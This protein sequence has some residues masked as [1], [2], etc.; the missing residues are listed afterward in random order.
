M[1]TLGRKMCSPIVPPGVHNASGYLYCVVIGWWLVWPSLRTSF[2]G[3]SRRIKP[4]ETHHLESAL[5]KH[6]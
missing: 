1:Y 4:M 3:K 2:R 5:A 6:N